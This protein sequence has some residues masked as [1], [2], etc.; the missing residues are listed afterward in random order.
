MNVKKN[1]VGMV[2]KI[3]VFSVAFLS[4]PLVAFAA[5]WCSGLD[6]SFKLFVSWA[7]TSIMRPVVPIIVSLTVVYFLWGT[8]LYIWYGDDLGKRTEGRQKMLI[9][10]IALAVMMSFWAAARML[11]VTFFG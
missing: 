8:A 7:I 4:V 9:G 1:F 11:K 3:C 5:P 6:C 2:K 10:I